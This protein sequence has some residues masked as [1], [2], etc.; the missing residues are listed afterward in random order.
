MSDALKLIEQSS[1]AR[2]NG[3]HATASMLAD[4]A[5]DMARTSGDQIEL[6]AAL[7]MLGRLRRDEHE[8]QA[9]V[10]FYER[11]AELA[12]QSG[13]EAALAQRLRH[14][15][16][17]LT[18]QGE[19][20]RAEL[21]YDEAAPFFEA[22]EIG[23]LGQA[24]FLRSIALLKEKQGAHDAAADLW[25]KARALYAATGIEAGVQ[26]SDRRLGKLRTA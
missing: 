10:A 16:D 9:A 19:L 24:N 14:M 3:D 12:R 21:C 7:A 11:A 26:E 5:A 8:H 1:E 18:E 2:R 17:V 25:M 6:G 20:D 15:G 22:Q 13:D 4:D 23:Q